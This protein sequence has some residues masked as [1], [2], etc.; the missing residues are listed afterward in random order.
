MTFLSAMSQYRTSP[1]SAA[2]VTV[3]WEQEL[4]ELQ[5]LQFLEQEL[6][7]QELQKQKLQKHHLLIHQGMCDDGTES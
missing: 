1:D 6:R 3:P 7:E 5:E 2:T 4:Q